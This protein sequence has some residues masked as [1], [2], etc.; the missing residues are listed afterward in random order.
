VSDP[1]VAIA[2]WAPR[3]L[4]NGLPADDVEDLRAAIERGED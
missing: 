4:A 2:Q 3:F 1:R